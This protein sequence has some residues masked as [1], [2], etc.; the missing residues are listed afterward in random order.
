MRLPA[1]IIGGRGP[2]TLGMVRSLSRAD[3]PV[4]LLDE[5]VFAP[6]MHTRY[7]HKIVISRLGGVPLVKELLALAAAIA[8]P[9]VLFLNSDDAVL[10]FRIPGRTGEKLPISAAEPCLRDLT[11]Q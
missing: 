11:D 7:G 9:A 4:I 8:G 5:D 3:V 10:S 2:G 6:A 1:V